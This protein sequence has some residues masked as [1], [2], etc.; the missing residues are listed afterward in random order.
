MKP[1]GFSIQSIIKITGQRKS[2]EMVP[3]GPSAAGDGGG[4]YCGTVSGGQ[5]VS[6]GL[7]LRESR[8]FCRNLLIFVGQDGICG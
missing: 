7:R 8:N 1:M 6:N 4:A 3:A 5:D 2:G